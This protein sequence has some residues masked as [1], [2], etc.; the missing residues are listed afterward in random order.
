MLLCFAVRNPCK[1]KN[2]QILSLRDGGG[3]GGRKFKSVFNFAEMRFFL[4]EK[5][6]YYEGFEDNFRVEGVGGGR[7]FC[8]GLEKTKHARFSFCKDSLLV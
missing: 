8:N 6:A 5:S 4:L 3:R 7:Q 2:A 1:N